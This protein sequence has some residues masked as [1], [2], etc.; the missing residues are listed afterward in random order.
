MFQ[1]KQLH[2]NTHTHTH[3]KTKTEREVEADDCSFKNNKEMK[4]NIR[5]TTNGEIKRVGSCYFSKRG[6]RRETREKKKQEKAIMRKEAE[7][8][9]RLLMVYK[10]GNGG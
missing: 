5:K 2:T 6:E 1:K 3:I 4:R 10:G 7:V 9:M 8:S